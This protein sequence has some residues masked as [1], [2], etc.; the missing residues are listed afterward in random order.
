MRKLTGLTLL[1]G[2]L[3][4]T[5]C[6]PKY[7]ACNNDKDCNRDQDRHEFCVNQLCQQCRDSNDCKEGQSCNQGRCEAIP[8]WCKDNSACEAGQVCIGNK[9]QSCTSDDQCG[10]GGKCGHSG[11]CL[12][13]GQCDDDADCGPDQSCQS[14][15]CV[16]KET[17]PSCQ[18]ETVYFDFNESVLSTE[19]SSTIDRDLACIRQNN[20][21]VRLVGHADPRGTEE[22]N[23]ALS[24]KRAM[25]VRDRLVRLGLQAG[26][27]NT[28]GK[29]ELDA[30]GT[31]EESWS[32]DRRVDF[33]WR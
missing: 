33:E 28:V 15:T 12:Q 18:L 13:P 21:P 23:M 31:D 30:T 32:K 22:Y 9:C 5:G 8:G 6:P 24:E 2:G 27:I 29:G 11:R 26:Q 4:L 3:L 20:R 19:A 17:Q 10:A 16:A 14:G 7:P 1:L 25:S